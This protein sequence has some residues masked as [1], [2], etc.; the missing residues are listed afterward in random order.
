MKNIV[1]SGST[2]LEEKITYWLDY[3][4]NKKYNILDYPVPI[5]ENVF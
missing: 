5:Q 1:I 4:K 3:F 2:K